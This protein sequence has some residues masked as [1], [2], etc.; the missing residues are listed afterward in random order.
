MSWF[1]N[2]TP[3]TPLRARE[4]I[5]DCAKRHNCPCLPRDLDWEIRWV[6]VDQPGGGYRLMHSIIAY[7]DEL[8]PVIDWLIEQPGNLILDSTIAFALHHR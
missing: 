2:A 4:A 6:V 8:D 1:D 5:I 3:M 7:G